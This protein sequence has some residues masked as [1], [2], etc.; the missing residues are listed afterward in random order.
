MPKRFDWSPIRDTDVRDSRTNRKRV[1][2]HRSRCD[3]R[4]RKRGQDE[5]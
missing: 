5:K 4:P 2:L 3:K 1:N